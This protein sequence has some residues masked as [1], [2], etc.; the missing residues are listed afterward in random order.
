MAWAHPCVADIICP[1]KAGARLK[2]QTRGIAPP[3]RP[4]ARNECCKVRFLS[5]PMFPQAP[6]QRQ[7]IPETAPRRPRDSPGPRLAR[8]Q[9]RWGNPRK[10]CACHGHAVRGGPSPGSGLCNGSATKLDYHRGRYTASNIVGACARYCWVLRISQ[11]SVNIVIS[12]VGLNAN[13]TPHI[14]STHKTRV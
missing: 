11:L 2:G 7:R 6:D 3:V 4:T 12:V 13:S 8:G 10:T 1:F 5:V 14:G 9:P